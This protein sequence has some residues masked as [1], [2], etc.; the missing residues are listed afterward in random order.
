MP[1]QT[2]TSTQT[3]PGYNRSFLQ[4][5]V[6]ADPETPEAELLRIKADVDLISWDLA[7]ALDTSERRV[8]ILEAARTYPAPQ[9]ET[10]RHQHNPF[11]CI[12]LVLVDSAGFACPLPAELGPLPLHQD[13]DG[14][15]SVLGPPLSHAIPGGD[16]ANESTGTNAGDTLAYDRVNIST[17]LTPPRGVASCGSSR[18]PGISGPHTCF[19]RSYTCTAPG[20]TW[21]TPFK[22]KQALDRHYEVIHLAE[23][24][25]CPVPGC[26][27][28]G[29][30]G[31]KKYDNLVAHMRG[32]HGASPACGAQGS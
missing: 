18:C 22:T 4:T 21:P 9:S 29:E 15:H 23:R 7:D 25:G 2:R 6:L 11:S 19:R 14:F 3:L 1:P 5:F 28:V 26:E 31:I 20:C 12:Q 10:E 32:K 24:L 8:M 16:Q 17:T 27:N 30:K 13:D